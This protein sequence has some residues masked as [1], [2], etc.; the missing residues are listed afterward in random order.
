[1]A[2]TI[3]DVIVSESAYVDLNTLS[4]IVAG[5]AMILEN[6]SRTPIRIQ[7]AGSQPSADSVDGSIL[8]GSNGNNPIKF[9]TAGENTVWAKSVE[10]LATTINVQDNT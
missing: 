7:I 6:K 8:T 1:M 10:D 5:T 9:V 3:P 2:D 4:S